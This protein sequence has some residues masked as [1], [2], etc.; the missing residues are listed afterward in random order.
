MPGWN[1]WAGE[2]G[3]TATEARGKA[4]IKVK[5]NEFDDADNN[6]EW[7]PDRNGRIVPFR[8]HAQGG[9]TYKYRDRILYT[10]RRVTGV[11][12]E[13]MFAHIQRGESVSPRRPQQ[14][15]G[16]AGFSFLTP[17]DVLTLTTQNVV[18]RRYVLLNIEESTARLADTST[19][20]DGRVCTAGDIHWVP[21][22]ILT[23]TVWRQETIDVTP[24]HAP[25]TLAVYPGSID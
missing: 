9:C 22:T 1:G 6:Q 13:E 14:K 4:G 12:L 23:D 5:N 17:G 7:T 8:E 15:G 25:D 16:L 3:L 2:A 24:L 19:D 10:R 20:E 18:E 21:I 11:E